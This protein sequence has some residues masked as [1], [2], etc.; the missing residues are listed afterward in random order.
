MKRQ[1]TTLL[2]VAMVYALVPTAHAAVITIGATKDASLFQNN[3]N[4]SSG[5]GNGLIVG[6]N[7]QSSPRR[8]SIAFDVAGSIPANA[9]IQNVQLNLILGAV[10]GGGGPGGGPA[11][12]TIGLHELLANW[13]EGTTQQQNPPN[14]NL[15]GQGQGAAAGNGDVTWNSNFHS[16]SL[17]GAPGG[18]FA[19]SASASAVVGTTLNGMNSWLSTPSLVSDVQGW[20]D[21]PGSNF[22]W[23]MVNADE[24]TAN[25]GRTFYSRN[26][27]TAAFHP[28]LEITYEAIP[29]PSAATIA[30]A[31]V[32]ACV[33]ASAG[34][35]TR[36]DHR[37]R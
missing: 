18:D 34:G 23:L 22:G 12:A 8:A 24:A 6:T 15:G 35:R 19:G 9:T 4:N 11:T 13:G 14:D 28:Q 37:R 7:A 16:T 25:T 36:R 17:W 20:L 3:V 30:L 29:E 21:S 33:M 2:A 26:V 31:G 32:A 1:L 5:A 27:A 10:A